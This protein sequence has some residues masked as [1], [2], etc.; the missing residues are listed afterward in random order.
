MP[1]SQLAPNLP[2]GLFID[3]GWVNA[4]SAGAMEHVN[5]TTGRVQAS[6]PIAGRAEVDDAVAAA[7]DA[8]RAFRRWSPVQRREL[9]NRIASLFRAH[10]AEFETIATLECGMVQPVASRMGDSAAVW[11]DYYAGWPD[12]LVGEVLPD[13]SSFDYVRYE[14][15]GVVA[16]ILT[17]NG[18]IGSIGMKVAAALAAGCTIVLKAPE[19]APF[20]ANLFGRLCTEAGVPHGVVNVI[21]GGPDAGDALVRHPGVHKIS[22]TGGPATARRIQAAAAETLK[23]LVLELGGKSATIVFEDAD[24]GRAAT[25]GAIAITRLAGQQCHGATRLVVQDTVYDRVVAQVGE[26]MDGVKVGDPRDPTIEMGPVISAGAV[27]RI[28]A[29]IRDA[30]AS[31]LGRLVAGG[32]RLGGPLAD[33]FFVRPTAFAD[34]DNTSSLAQEEIFGP[35]LSIIRFHDEDEAVAI[36]NDS[37]YG[38]AANIYTSDIRRAI[39]V[40]D[41][42]DVGNVG[43]NG[44]ATNAGPYGPFGGFGQSGYGKEGGLHGVQEFLRAKNVNISLD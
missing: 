26:V 12:K 37:R 10:A 4:T 36:A 28:M 31:S 6:F 33:G 11:F 22:F 32:T 21:T 35:V 20:G 44:G 3:G 9:L 15:Y 18:P 2:T 41:A 17:W 30:Q 40:S 25:N 7:K 23:P 24:L 43:I 38:L 42:L 5:P 1:L 8:L 14:P 39:R 34:V 29:T 16:I 19:L 13:R 27:E